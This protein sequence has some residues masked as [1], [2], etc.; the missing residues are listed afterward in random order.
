MEYVFV[1]GFHCFV[2]VAVVFFEFFCCSEPAFHFAVCL[3]VVDSGFY[4]F[5][6]VMFECLLE[7]VV[8]WFWAGFSYHG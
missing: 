7:D 3:W 4:V 8:L 1:V 6:A 2:Q 5:D